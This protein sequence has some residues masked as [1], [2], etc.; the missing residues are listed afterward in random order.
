MIY[1]KKLTFDG[2]FGTGKVSLSGAGAIDEGILGYV[3]AL[4]P[5]LRNVYHA[6][7]EIIMMIFGLS[8]NSGNCK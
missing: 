7:I 6:K 5:I 4:L 2:G 3:I 1:K 8:L